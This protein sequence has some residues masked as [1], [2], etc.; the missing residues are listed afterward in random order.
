MRTTHLVGPLA[1]SLSLAGLLGLTFVTSSRA[2]APV[3]PPPAAPAAA[4]AVVLS[5]DPAASSIS[6]HMVHKLHKFDATSKK[7]EG[8]VRILPTGVAQSRC[9]PRWSRLT[10]VTAT[11]TPT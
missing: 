7:V 2:D 6:Y 9:A 1:R 8:K 10:P 3:A 11:A 5:A 4:T